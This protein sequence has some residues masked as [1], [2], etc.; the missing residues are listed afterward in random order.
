MDLP[1]ILP[2]GQVRPEFHQDDAVGPARRTQAFDPACG[3][4]A[5]MPRV[6]Q[7]KNA[8]DQA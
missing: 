5:T 2:G 8:C 7:E 6:F 4:A 3:I 1:D